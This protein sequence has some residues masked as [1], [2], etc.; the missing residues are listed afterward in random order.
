MRLA[1]LDLDRLDDCTPENRWG[2]GTERDR[3]LYRDDR[4]WYKIW[5]PLYLAASPYASG[6]K[7][8]KHP[9][10]LRQPH[11]F[12]VGLFTPEISGAFETFI[13]DE[14][15]IVRGYVTRAGRKPRKVTDTFVESVF[16]ACVASGWAYGD[17][18]YNNVVEVDTQLSLI[19]F[20]THLTK[21]DTMDI[22]FEEEKGALRPHVFPAFRDLILSE[23]AHRTE[24]AARNE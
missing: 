22:A 5:G 4:Y 7:F 9:A 19:D 2:A 11:G 23:L 17:F 20:D 18:C 3:F 8:H 6:G 16:Q 13:C 21:F 12:E 24:L 14:D 10:P 15:N 1:D